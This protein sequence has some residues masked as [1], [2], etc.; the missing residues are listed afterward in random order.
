[1]IVRWFNDNGIYAVHADGKTPTK[2]RDDIM[3][4]FKSK[5][6]LYYQMSI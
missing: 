3:A 2:E 6:S 4:N 1:M 5:K